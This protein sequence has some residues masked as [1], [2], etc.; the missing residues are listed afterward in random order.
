MKPKNPKPAP[1][2]DVPETRLEDLI[3]CTGYQGPAKTLEEM[4]AGIALGARQRPAPCPPS[5]DPAQV[6]QRQRNSTPS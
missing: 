4:E 3:G 6:G 5:A 2:Q 1:V